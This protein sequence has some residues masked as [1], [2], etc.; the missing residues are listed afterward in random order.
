VRVWSEFK[1]L[2]IGTIIRQAEKVFETLLKIHFIVTGAIMQEDFIIYTFVY[3]CR[4]FQM[5]Y[6]EINRTLS[7]TLYKKVKLSL[8]YFLTEHHAMKAYWGS[9]C[10]APRIL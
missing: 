10:I 9:A 8:C 7:K 6:R 3:L 1:W 4:K 2:K 5:Y